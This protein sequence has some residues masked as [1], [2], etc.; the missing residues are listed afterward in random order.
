[1][2]A[3]KRVS[4]SFGKNWEQFL[5][6]VKDENRRA[7]ELSLTEFLSMHDLR[8][9]TF[10]DVGCG[11]GLFSLAAF[12][13]GAER[14]V[15]FDVDPYSVSCCRFLRERENDPENWIVLEGSV[16]DHEFISSLGSFDI[17]YA[18]GVLH[19]AGR[20]WEAVRNAATLVDREGYYYLAL[21]NRKTGRFG[22][23]FWLEVKKL[24]NASPRPGKYMIEVIYM[25][26]FFAMQLARL[27]NPLARIKNYSSNRGMNWR[28]DVVDWLGGYPYEFAAAE[29]VRDFIK[30]HFPN[31]NQAKIEPAIGRGMNSFLFVN[32]PS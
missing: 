29:D 10:L 19:H 2:V 5:K 4:F 22:S 3:E 15:S 27:K 9:K 25:S 24:Y 6:S 7:A 31:F 18:W 32:G 28:R 26:I 11:S 14:I 20:M 23:E 30:K 13:L 1:M 12:S 17:V 21:Y 16:L 8:G